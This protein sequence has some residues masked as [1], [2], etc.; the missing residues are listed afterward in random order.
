ML[1][2]TAIHLTSIFLTWKRGAEN[3][4]EKKIKK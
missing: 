1:N 3:C 2:V 4:R